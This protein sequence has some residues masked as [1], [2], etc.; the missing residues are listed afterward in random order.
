M[1]IISEIFEKSQVPFLAWTPT[2]RKQKHCVGCCHIT[3][4]H[5]LCTS[6]FISNLNMWHYTFWPTVGL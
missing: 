6:P 1:S 5:I 2:T 4:F 3:S